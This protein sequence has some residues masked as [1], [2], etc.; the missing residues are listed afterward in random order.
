VAAARKGVGRERGAGIEGP[1][2]V[3]KVADTK[4]P[5]ETKGRGLITSDGT[6]LLGTDDKAGVAVSAA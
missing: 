1:S 3:I 2:K 5:G 6:T 4:G